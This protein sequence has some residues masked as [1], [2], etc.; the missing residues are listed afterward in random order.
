MQIKI[1]LKIVFFIIVF[2]ITKQIKVYG[3]LMIFAFFHELGHLVAGILL[4]FKPKSITINPLGLAINFKTKIDDYNNKILKAN[5]LAVKK[6]IIAICGPVVNFAIAIFVYSYN[7]N[8]I[9]TQNEVI[10]IANILIGVFNLIPIYPLDGGRILKNI[11]YIFSGLEKSNTYMNIVSNIVIIILTIISSISIMYFKN[12]AILLAI[13]Y[14]WVLVIN[15]NRLF[16]QK[17]KIYNEVKKQMGKQKENVN[18]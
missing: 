3:I 6:M 4:G 15:D 9:G 14:L 18:V 1:N 17:Q 8:F 16:S 2:F 10:V 13:A 12:I 5:T 11:L 7:T